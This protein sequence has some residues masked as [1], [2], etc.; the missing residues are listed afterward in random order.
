[1]ADTHAGRDD[2]KAFE[3]LLRPIQQG[4]SFAVAAVLPLQVGGIRVLTA[5]PIDLHR[6]IDYQID[7]DEGIDALGVTTG[8][9]IALRKAARSTTAGTPVKSCISTRVGMNAMEAS[10]PFGHWA[11]ATTSASVT[12]RPPTLR[13]IFSERIWTVCERPTS[14]RRLGGQFREAH[15]GGRTG[16]GRQSRSDAEWIVCHGL[17]PCEMVA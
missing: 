9:A 6:V 8:R 17:P 5:K 4:V 15:V 16:I 14:V 3:R 2:S 1:M 7:W 12:S 13:A 10:V 11:S